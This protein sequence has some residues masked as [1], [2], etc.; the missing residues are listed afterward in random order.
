MTSSQS[1]ETITVT[2]VNDAPVAVDDAYEVDEDADLTVLAAQGVLANDTDV[3]NDLLTATLVNGPAHGTLVLAEDGSFVY[4]PEAN[5][6]GTDSFTYK[7]TDGTLESNLATVTITV[8]PVNDWPV[9]NDDEYEVV[10]GTVLEVAAPGVLGN[11][12]LLDLDEQVSIQVLEGPQHGTLTLNN[13]GSF[14]YTPNAGYMGVD[15]FRYLVLSQQGKGE[16]SDDATVTITVKPSMSL[17][18]PIIMR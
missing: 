7:A 17:F 16:W 11:D 18:L 1:I 3:D 10:T 13:D 4:T 8:K 5:F 15:T 14:T 6:N 12:V 9:A 2:P